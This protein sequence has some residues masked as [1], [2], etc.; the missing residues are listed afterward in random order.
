VPVFR[1]TSADFRFLL[2][3]LLALPTE[4]WRGAEIRRCLA[5]NGY[6]NLPGASITA[7]KCFIAVVV[8]LKKS[9]MKK[10]LFVLNLFFPRNLNR[11]NDTKKT[12]RGGI[13][14]LQTLLKVQRV[15]LKDTHFCSTFAT[16]I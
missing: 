12:N 8:G 3:H 5:E 14:L 13:N 15:L 4:A 6:V 11:W 16:I 2:P 7:V 9:L 1:S 10:Q